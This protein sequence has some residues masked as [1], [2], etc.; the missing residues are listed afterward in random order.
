MTVNSHSR[1][2]VFVSLK[3]IFTVQN[4]AIDVRNLIVNSNSFS[5][6][7]SKKC[8]LFWCTCMRKMRPTSHRKL[9]AKN[10]LT[11]KQ[12]TNLCKVFDYHNFWR[13]IFRLLLTYQQPSAQFPLNNILSYTIGWYRGYPYR[14]I[15]LFLDL[16]SWN[17]KIY[18]V[19]PW[20]VICIFWRPWSVKIPITH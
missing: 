11:V 7:I 3:A 10:Q 8:T 1:V 16:D 19:S 4:F 15:W 12:I 9:C 13:K 2:H 20:C 17:S 14:V 5:F 18:S 6:P